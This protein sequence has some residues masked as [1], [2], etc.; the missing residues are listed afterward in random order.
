MTPGAR[1]PRARPP[2]PPL[3]ARTA[4][5]RDGGGGG[6][7]RAAGRGGR[8]AGAHT[9]TAR[10]TGKQLSVRPTTHP[11]RAVELRGKRT[12]IVGDLPRIASHRARN[13]PRS[14]GRG[15]GEGGDILEV[16]TDKR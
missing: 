13:G 11:P 12:A 3:E 16:R 8:A 15:G 6:G 4:S 1:P 14:S 5:R 2:P 7:G 10:R 9:R